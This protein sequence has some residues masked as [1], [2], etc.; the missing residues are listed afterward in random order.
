MVL[1]IL[2]LCFVS[3]SARAAQWAEVLRSDV[4]VHQLPNRTSPVIGS[5]SEGERVPVSDSTVRDVYGERWYKTATDQGEYGYVRAGAVRPQ[6]IVRERL[7]A[8]VTPDSLNR[9]PREERPWS[10]SVRVA[11][12]G[13]WATGVKT[14]RIGFTGDISINVGPEDHG[15]GSRRFAIGVGALRLHD[16][17]VIQGMGVMRF[18]MRG[19]MEPEVRLHLGVGNRPVLDSVYPAVGASIRFRY[20]LSLAMT[21]VVALNADFGV[22]SRPDPDGPSQIWAGLGLGFHF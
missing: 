10:V 15:F 5:R 18:F 11:P 6:D 8:G 21:S 7:A 4:P 2:F 19:R 22:L 1:A 13:G 12:V 9:L 16:T 14:A 20:P 3:A 17:T